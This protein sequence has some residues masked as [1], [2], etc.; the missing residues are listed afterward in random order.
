MVASQEIKTLVDQIVTQFKPEKV[1][2]FGSHAY[3]NPAKDS[4]VDLLVVM[5]FKGNSALKAAE[6]LNATNPNFPIDMIVR[7]PEQV[8]KR[9]ELG[10]FF[11]LDVIEKGE[12]LYEAAY[13]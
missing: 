6:I 10:D 2:L 8:R 12:I 4:D 1:I 11:I 9:M 3:G 13:A 7:T 5:E